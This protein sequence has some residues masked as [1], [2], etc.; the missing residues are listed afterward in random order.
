[1]IKFNLKCDNYDIFEASFDDSSS[2]E[3]QRK[4][5]FTIFGKGKVE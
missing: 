2:F 1:M 3:K 4:K 5:K